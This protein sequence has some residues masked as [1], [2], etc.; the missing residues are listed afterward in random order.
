MH[1]APHHAV[2]RDRS[3]ETVAR[4]CEETPAVP[5]ALRHGSSKLR[6]ETRGPGAIIGGNAPQSLRAYNVS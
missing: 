5:R 4:R 2:R 1:V 3:L 6:T